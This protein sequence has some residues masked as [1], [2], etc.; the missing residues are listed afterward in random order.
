MISTTTASITPNAT[1][2]P[3]DD[4]TLLD[5]VATCL[6]VTSLEVF[7]SLLSFKDGSIVD[8]CSIGINSPLVNAL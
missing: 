5:V 1:F 3:W 2:I 8:S 7:K 4:M 6:V